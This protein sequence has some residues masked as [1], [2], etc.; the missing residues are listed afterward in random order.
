[1]N[2]PHAAQ[3]Y[4]DKVLAKAMTGYTIECV[5]LTS[6]PL[7]ETRGRL[8]WIG[9]RC[10]SFNAS[11][12]KSQIEFIHKASEA[13]P[14]QNL[15]PYFI[16][17]P[18]VEKDVPMESYWK[19]EAKYNE[20]F[21]SNMAKLVDLKK[22]PADVK[23]PELSMRPSRKFRTLFNTGPWMRANGDVQLL[24]LEQDRA[25]LDWMP[26]TLTM[27]ADL[28]QSCHRA[29]TSLTGKWGTIT[30]SRKLFDFVSGKFLSPSAHMRM[31]GMDPDFVSLRGVRDTEPCLFMFVSICLSHL[32]QVFD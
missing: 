12:W 30:T 4:Y 22:L 6:A 23:V 29:Q 21:A 26:E 31:L 32:F 11:T 9:S 25:K 2:L 13:M 5:E 15:H 17:Y 28:S 7:P 20:Y 3:E 1:M 16:A 18:Q 27:V 24:L 19:D 8:W 10:D 14:Q